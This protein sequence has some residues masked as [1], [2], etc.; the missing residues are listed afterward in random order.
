MATFPLQ[1][2][3]RLPDECF[4]RWRLTDNSR[5]TVSMTLADYKALA[6]PGAGPPENTTGDPGAVWINAG[7]HA[8]FDTADGQLAPGDVAPW[9]HGPDF[10]NGA[11]DTVLVIG[12]PDGRELRARTADITRGSVNSVGTLTLN[13]TRR[14]GVTVVDGVLEAPD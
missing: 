5:V 4:S 9:G 10:C 8:V 14:A 2:V 12:M 3:N 11:G 7:S 1:R 6:L 13:N